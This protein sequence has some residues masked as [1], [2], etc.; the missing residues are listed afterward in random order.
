MFLWKKRILSVSI[1]CT[2]NPQMQQEYIARR[3]L[4]YAIMWLSI[5]T[6]KNKKLR[7]K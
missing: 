4:N 2:L 3:G 1:I 6:T 5:N 7:N